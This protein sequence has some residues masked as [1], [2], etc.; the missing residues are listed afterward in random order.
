MKTLFFLGFP[1]PFP[2]AGWTR[3]SFFA[4]CFKNRGHDVTVAG[5]FSPKSV[6]QAGVKCWKGIR[7]YN[8][9]PTFW[10]EGFPSLIFNVFLSFIVYPLLML[11][12]RPQ[13]AVVSV[14]TGEPAVGAFFSS[15]LVGAKVVFDVRD[16]WEDY[17]ISKASSH[18]YR[19]IYRLFKALMASIYAKSDLV[20]AVTPNIVRSLLLR[21]VKEV[22][23]VPNGADVSVF[24][25]YEKASMREKLGLKKDDFILVY[26]GG[27]GGYYR[28]DIVVKA[29]ARLNN[30]MRGKIKL[31]IVGSGDMPQLIR[32]AEKLGLKDNVVYLG[33]R[34]DRKE[35]AQILSAGD[36]GIVPYDDNLL[37]KNSVSAKFY[38][39]CACGLPVVAT[40]YEDSILAKLIKENGI[41]LT[42]RPM[43]EE[44]LAEAICHL[45]ENESFRVVAGRRAREMV[46]VKFDRNK[47]AEE[48]LNL[49][50]VLA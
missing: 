34:N 1:N 44:K 46:E 26:S 20:V 12:L 14:P 28:L 9:C 16:E 23:L 35:L 10:V 40:V 19:A 11:L 33:V 21:G 45:Y 15:K 31:L 17:V 41:G 25:P 42:A 22:K 5:V 4:T 36:V 30:V 48:F 37:W 43:D 8:L 50:K 49:I 2:G 47:I 3:V 24:R 39:Y 13:L 18:T 6:R 38:E 29:M 7:I 27:V 32:L